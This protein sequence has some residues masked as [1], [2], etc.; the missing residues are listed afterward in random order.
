VGDI[1]QEP[2]QL[3]GLGADRAE[4][5]RRAQMWLER[6]G[7][8]PAAVSRYPFEFSGGQRQRIAIARCLTLSPSVVVLDEAVS[9]LD[10]SVQAQVLNLLKD[11]QNELN[12]SYLFI[13]HDL[14][15]VRYMSDEVLV[16]RNGQQME[17]GRVESL[18][19]A[20]ATAYT[21]ELLE[22]I[23]RGWVPRF[24]A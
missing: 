16:M 12:L 14:G 21:Q 19:A 22:A 20:P 8:P 6:V 18:Y 24:P 3:H 1:L 13:S 10:V 7:L 11:L 2:M 15:V 4:R 17:R 9:A 23:P 5:L